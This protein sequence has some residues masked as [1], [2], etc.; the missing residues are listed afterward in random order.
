MFHL[1]APLTQTRLQKLI[2]S[3]TRATILSAQSMLNNIVYLFAI[4]AGGFI[5]DK[6]GP[7]TGMGIFILLLL[8]VLIMYT[9]LKEKP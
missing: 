3:K 4:P 6:V 5:L 7:K 1:Q 9:F 8:P 2:P